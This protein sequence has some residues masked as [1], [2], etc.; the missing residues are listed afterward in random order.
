MV[1][2]YSSNVHSSQAMDYWY[3]MM[4]RGIES[5]IYIEDH[6]YDF[7]PSSKSIYHWWSFT[8][9]IVGS[10]MACS[11]INQPVGRPLSRLS[12][13]ENSFVSKSCHFMVMQKV[14][15]SLKGTKKSAYRKT[16]HCIC[17]LWMYVTKWPPK[18]G[19]A[20]Q[21]PLCTAPQLDMRLPCDDF[22][23]TR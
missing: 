7:D 8:V 14:V 11:L 13:G 3:W 12:P 5:Y 17:G 2:W 23:N 21:F 15:T 18:F 22:T 10:S 20:S 6:S 4:T 16:W 9:L 1:E 19:L